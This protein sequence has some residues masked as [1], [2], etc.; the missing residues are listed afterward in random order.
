[1]QLGQ[2]LGQD[3]FEIIEGA[4][5]EEHV[6]VGTHRPTLLGLEAF[7]VAQQRDP[8]AYLA[9]PGRGQS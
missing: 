7:T 1:M 5:L 3:L 4:A 9:L 6:P 2:T 8:A